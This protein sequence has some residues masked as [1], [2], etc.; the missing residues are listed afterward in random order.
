MREVI[1]AAAESGSRERKSDAGPPASASF[2]KSRR[3]NVDRSFWFICRVLVVS[4]APEKV[5]G[6]FPGK[7]AGTFFCTDHGISL[8]KDD[9]YQ[10]ETACPGRKVAGTFLGKVPATFLRRTIPDPCQRRQ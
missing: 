10:Q 9:Q 7:V 1:F 2:V 8:R 6:T 5:A 4:T 3:V